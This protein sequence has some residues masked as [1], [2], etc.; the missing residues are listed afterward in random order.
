[1]LPGY[2]SRRSA[3]RRKGAARYSWFSRD[4]LVE[5]ARRGGA[6]GMAGTQSSGRPRYWLL[7]SQ[8]REAVES[9]QSLPGARLPGENDVMREQGVARAT[10]RQALAQ[11]VNWALPS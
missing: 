5:V 8:L 7:A 1:C 11:L 4:V 3:M 10:A 6:K 2:G 9:G